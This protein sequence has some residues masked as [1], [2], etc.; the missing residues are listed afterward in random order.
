[1]RSGE[2]AHQRA[3]QVHLD[4]VVSEVPKR[5]LDYLDLG[6]F[7]TKN[8][9]QRTVP[10]SPALKELLQRRLEKLEPEDHVFTRENKHP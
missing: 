9:T 2:I 4:K 3:Y 7:D 6:I 5:E 10:V 8:K 1:M